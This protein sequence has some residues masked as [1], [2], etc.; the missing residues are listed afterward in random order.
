MGTVLFPETRFLLITLSVL[1]AEYCLGASAPNIDP[2]YSQYEKD[3]RV[4]LAKAT[5]LVGKE[6]IKVEPLSEQF[7]VPRKLSIKGTPYELGLTL[8]QIGKQAG[9]RLPLLTETN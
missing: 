7:T 6:V 5:K 1:L 8:G 3:L 9:F 2:V 4:Y